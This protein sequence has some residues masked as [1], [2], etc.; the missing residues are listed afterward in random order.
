MVELEE[1][2]RQEVLR[3]IR[4]SR[5]AFYI[6]YTCVAFLLGLL[7]TFQ[8]KG[9]ALNENLQLAVLGI[10][11][12][13]IGS[14]EI[15]RLMLR[16]KVTES[17]IMIINGFLKQTKKNVYFQPLAYVP[18]LNIKQGRLQRL[19]GYGTVYLKSGGESTFEIKDVNNPQQIL[20][21]IEKLIEHNKR[22][23]DDPREVPRL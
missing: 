2:K 23:G 12:V 5:K 1:Q 15:A 9:I 6:E 3:T 10:S 18:D 22:R 13:S 4:K 7:V 17:K 20:E 19:L 8:F 14:A 21:M 11:L 16:Y